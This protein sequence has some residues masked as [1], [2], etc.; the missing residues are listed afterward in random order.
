MSSHILAALYKLKNITRW[1]L[2]QTLEKENVAEH[3]YNVSLISYILCCIAEEVFNE[4]VPKYEILV[5]SL[6]HDAHEIFTTDIPA[7]IKYYNEDSLRHY[8]HL[9]GIATDRIIDMVPKRFKKYLIPLI[10]NEN[11]IIKKWVKAA[12]LCDTYLKCKKELNLGNKSFESVEK[13]VYSS[14]LELNM[15]TVNYFL[16]ELVP[17]F[18]KSFDDILNNN[19]FNSGLTFISE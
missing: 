2:L 11:S 19:V 16:K 10:C 8:R 9:E 15:P 13:K 14:L 7:P 1:E 17:S 12:D 5:A 6:G 4:N 18:D 3:S